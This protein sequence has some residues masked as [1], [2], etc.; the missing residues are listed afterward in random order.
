M[1]ELADAQAAL[2]QAQADLASARTSRDQALAA[3]SPSRDT[4]TR[5]GLSAIQEILRSLAQGTGVLPAKATLTYAVAG[6]SWPGWPL[7]PF[8]GQRMAQG[9]APGQFTYTP[10]ADG[11]WSLVAHLTSGDYTLTQG[12]FDWAARKDLLTIQGAT[13]I[14]YGLEI[15]SILNNDLYPAHLSSTTLDTVDPWPANPFTGASMAESTDEGDFDYAAAVNGSDY[16][17]VANLNDGSS[18]DVASWTQPLFAPLWRLRISLKDMAAQAYTQVLKDYVDEWKLDH[19]GELPTAQQ[20]SPSGA[21]GAAHTWWPRNP[22]TMAPMGA[23]TSTGDFEYVPGAGG[24][25]TIVLHQ[26]PLPMVFFFNDTATTE[27][28]TAQ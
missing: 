6:S 20:M 23:G 13:F 28:Y 25:F 4:A 17:L 24:A 21:V 11:S 14:S 9:T 15:W 19:S 10:G 7:S 18:Y 2:S 1:A 26:Q 16:D 8:D 5:N 27:I 3:L 22:W 12:A